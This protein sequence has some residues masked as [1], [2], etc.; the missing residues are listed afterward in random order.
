[1]TY[2]LKLGDHHAIE[3]PSH[4][5]DETHAVEVLKSAF[6]QMVRGTLKEKGW[7]ELFHPDGH[8]VEIIR[9][10]RKDVYHEPQ[11]KLVE[12]K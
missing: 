7:A 10:T 6:P 12:N 9:D 11:I 5:H 4:V 3:F 8:V 2:T 1:M